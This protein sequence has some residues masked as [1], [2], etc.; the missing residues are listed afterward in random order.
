MRL[1]ELVVF[2]ISDKWLLFKYLRSHILTKKHFIILEMFCRWS[3]NEK[4]NI[5]SKRKVTFKVYR[6]TKTV[7]RHLWSEFAWTS[8][9]VKKKK[10]LKQY[11]F[12]ISE[13]KNNNNDIFIVY[14]S[15]SKYSIENTRHTIQN[16]RETFYTII[17]LIIV[18]TETNS[19]FNSILVH[20]VTILL[21]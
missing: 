18:N 1:F 6:L 9:L 3:V 17:V 14:Q 11:V 2:L 16:G 8:L 12:C 13:I 7:T 10:L 5:I 15:Y 20:S 4:K 19:K 21:E